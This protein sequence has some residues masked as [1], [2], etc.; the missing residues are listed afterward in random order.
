MKVFVTIGFLLAITLPSSNYAAAEATETDGT[1]VL[2]GDRYELEVL[3]SEIPLN[4]SVS[5]DDSETKPKLG[6]LYDPI[7]VVAIAI[8]CTVLLA[9]GIWVATN[10]KHRPPKDDATKSHA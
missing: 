6:G 9:L 3:S 5:V 1:S 2:R 7:L 10:K 8:P 4:G